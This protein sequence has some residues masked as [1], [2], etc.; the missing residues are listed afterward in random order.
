VRGAA[1]SYTS[2]SSICMS[3][4]VTPSSSE[5]ASE[6]AIARVCTA[7]L[8]CTHTTDV[9]R[10]RRHPRERAAEFFVKHVVH[11][12]VSHLCLCRDCPP[13]SPPPNQMSEP[14][15][16]KLLEQHVASINQHVAQV[17]S[18]LKQPAVAQSLLGKRSAPE[19]PLADAAETSPSDFDSL[20]HTR[21][22]LRQ[23]ARERDWDQFHTPRNLCLAFVGEVGELAECFQWRGDAG[24]EP[25]LADWAAPKKE[26]LG[27]ELA[28]CL[29]YIVRLA[30]KCGVDL[31]AA[32]QRKLG[33][34]AA[35]YPAKLVKGSSKKYNEY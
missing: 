19:P 3:T 33:L 28:D 9:P 7:G 1:R 10:L 26:H 17:S 5:D 20:T 24:A 30:D 31:P 15:C 16:A 6:S 23:F 29:L 21:E 8:L 27:E 32:T 13:A 14:D 2:S 22:Y 35:K 4:I 25:G 34:N 11:S 18:L 12:E